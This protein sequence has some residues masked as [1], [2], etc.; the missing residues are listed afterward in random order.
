MVR[1]L[2][3]NLAAS[4]KVEQR[5]ARQTRRGNS[6]EAIGHYL[7]LTVD[8]TLTSQQS[9]NVQADERAEEGMRRGRARAWPDRS[10]GEGR[11]GVHPATKVRSQT[12]LC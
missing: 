6:T 9:P 2:C 1:R 7:N 11:G 5:L 3:G 4:G 10:A 12:N 8:G